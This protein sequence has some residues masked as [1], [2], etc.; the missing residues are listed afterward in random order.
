M[1]IWRFSSCE[2][3]AL[4]VIVDTA[5]SSNIS[6]IAIKSG[7]AYRNNQ[8]NS[9]YAEDAVKKF[10]DAGIQVY[11]WNHSKPSTWAAEVKQIASCF[12]DGADGHIINAESE[13]NGMSAEAGRFLKAL[14]K[15]VGADKFLAHAPLPLYNFNSSFPYAEFG[16]HVDAVMPQAYWTEQNKQMNEFCDVMDRSF[17]DFAKKYPEAVKPICPIGVTYGR[18]HVTKKV[19]GLFSADDMEAFLK[20]Y[21]DSSPSL[22]TWDAA[23]PTAFAKL[24][25]M[26]T[27]ELNSEPDEHVEIEADS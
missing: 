7:D 22:Y 4:D 9:R 3:G 16:K 6:W 17:A 21:E 19:P 18:G 27:A 20:R 12:D 25:A 10:H 15:Q 1:W 5:M 8:W 24:Q 26:R 13:W 14:R 11:T 23:F 2:M